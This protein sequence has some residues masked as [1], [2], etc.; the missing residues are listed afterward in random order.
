LGAGGGRKTVSKTRAITPKAHEREEKVKVLERDID[1][2]EIRK[3]GD[4]NILCEH[5]DLGW[6]VDESATGL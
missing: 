1:V 2:Q 3:R 5:L 4:G 6:P